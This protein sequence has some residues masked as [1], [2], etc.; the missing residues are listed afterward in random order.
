[1]FVGVGIKLRTWKER[2]TERKGMNSISRTHGTGGLH[3]KLHQ[4][5]ARE[6]RFAKQSPHVNA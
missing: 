2:E 4:M 5:L 1:M 3:A 6:L